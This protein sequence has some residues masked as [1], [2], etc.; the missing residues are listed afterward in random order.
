MPRG[1]HAGLPPAHR[2]RSAGAKRSC[3][4]ASRARQGHAPP[5]HRRQGGGRGGGRLLRAARGGVARGVPRGAGLA[6]GVHGGGGGARGGRRAD[7]GQ[8]PRGRPGP[9]A[10]RSHPAGG[11]T[12]GGRHHGPLR[13]VPLRVR[14]RRVGGGWGRGG[15]GGVGGRDGHGAVGDGGGRVGRVPRR[16]PPHHGR[17][18][19]LRRCGAIGPS[20]AEGG[21]VGVGSLGHHARKAEAGAWPC[22]A[23]TLHS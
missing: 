7:A 11:D 18:R 1:A 6:G 22:Q 2:G 19:S 14:Q 3:A 12:G 4:P 16:W 23:P 21:G 8:G 9:D 5:G 20:R 10:V 17:V 13:L 15:G